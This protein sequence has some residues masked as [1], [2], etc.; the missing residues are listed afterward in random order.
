VEAGV[1]MRGERAPLRAID[2]GGFP[3]VAPPATEAARPARA[4]SFAVVV[5]AYN[6]A[7][8]IAET[9]ESALAQTRPPQQVIVCDD[10]SSDATGEVARRYGARVTVVTQEN[11]GDAAARNRALGLATASHVVVLDADD[12]LERRCLEAYAAALLARPDL[13]IVTCDAFLE[14]DGR[15]FDRYYRKVARFVVDDQRRGVLHQHFIFGL[16]AIRREALLAVRGWDERIPRNSD[17]D[18]FLRLVLAGSRAG[19]V[20]EPLA[21]YRLRPGSLSSE[22]AAGMRTMV[23]IVERALRESAL[24]EDEQAYALADLREKEKLTRLAEL[25][26]ALRSGGRDTR[27]RALRVARAPALGYPARVRFEAYASAALPALGRMALRL[28]DRRHRVTPLR[29]RA[30]AG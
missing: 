25:E 27:E 23:Y 3:L 7:A 30:R 18:L 26:H 1:V 2:A 14:S 20:Y 15:I 4:T 24:S 11:R 13:D 12:V 17:T 29:T 8:T 28:R 22:R 16:A 6:A 19:L 5:A 9:L 10:G 21:R